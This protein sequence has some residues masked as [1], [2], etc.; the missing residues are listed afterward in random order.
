MR[1]AIETHGCRLNQAE[2]DAL[3]EQLRG[4]GHEQVDIEHAQLFVLNGC[5]ITH[6]ADADARAAIRRARRRNPD[7]KL[8]ITGC[9]ANVDPDRLAGMPELDAVIGNIEKRGPS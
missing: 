6:A 1:F 7:A 5:A 2:T 3:I 4:R 8:V 9:Q